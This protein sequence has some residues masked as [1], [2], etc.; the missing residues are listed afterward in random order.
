MWAGLFSL[1]PE[2]TPRTFLPRPPETTSSVRCPGVEPGF[3]CIPS[4]QITVFLAPDDAFSGYPGMISPGPPEVRF[5]LAR[6][7]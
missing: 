4:K 2:G 6:W 5:R 3:S 7:F 1:A